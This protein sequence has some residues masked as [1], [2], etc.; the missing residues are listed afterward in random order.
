MATLA[1]G[2]ESW[3]EKYRPATLDDVLG[4]PSAVREL[5][6]WAKA[7]TEGRPD[8]PGALLVGEAGIG[9]TSAAL[10][11][12]HEM[13]WTVVELNASDAR[14]A[15]V[16]ERVVTRGATSRGFSATG[17]YQA[18]E[19]KQRKLLILDEA[20][21]VFGRQ[22][23]GGMKQIVDT[24]KQTQQPIILTANDAY[25]LRRKSS[26]LSKHCK[27]IKFKRVQTTTVAKALASILKNEG[28]QADLQALELLAERSGGDLRAAVTDLEAVARG[29]E[30]LTMADVDTLGYRDARQSVFDALGTI[31]GG[32]DLKASQQ[33]SRELDEDPESL[34]LWVEEN[35]PREYT[36]L[37]D[38][39]RAMATLAR[40]DEFLGATRRTRYYRFWS[41]A[42]DLM[43]AG[44]TA[45]KKRPYKG[46]T[47]YQFPS[48][49][50]KMS[51]S[52]ANRQLRNDLGLKVGA[53]YHAGVATAR[54]HIIPPFSFIAQ[55]D[56]AFATFL[57][58][59][60]E[61]EADELALLLDTKP[62]TKKVKRILEAAAEDDEEEPTSPSSAPSS[63]A[64][65]GADDE[66]AEA[67]DEEDE[68]DG[69]QQPSLMD[70]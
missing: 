24:L 63:T 57:A 33:A 60:L 52:K 21:N 19:K 67:D 13:G 47:R 51:R 37:D 28:I 4:N 48:W 68:D 40:A 56:E 55:R 49:L 7:W 30:M 70:F 2:V 22:D 12:A 8:K 35:A 3:T 64:N 42:S 27:E 6:A 54:E 25:A 16:I 41:V 59:E 69:A 9:K 53:S 61:L 15:D 5:R 39:A 14:T 32:K 66:E 31:L 18:D 38:R 29:Q 10:A 1:P 65:P 44:V 62:S 26:S 11:L 34:L 45:A 17:E 43:T 23:R 46:W 50:R 36:D 58:A 20:D